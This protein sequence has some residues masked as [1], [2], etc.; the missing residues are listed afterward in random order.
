[1]PA[2]RA[3]FDPYEFEFIDWDDQEEEGS[4]LRHCLEHGVDEAVVDEVLRGR[5]VE[6]RLKLMTA[7]FAIVGPD[8]GDSVLWTLLFDRSYKP[9]TGYGQYGM[10][11]E[12]SG[13]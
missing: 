13:G 5:P 3:V 6:V 11:L 7:D 12:T 2:R 9:A 10:A 8:G 4:N 1:L